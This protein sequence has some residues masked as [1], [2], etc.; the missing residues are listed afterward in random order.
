MNVCVYCSS[1]DRVDRAFFDVA[2]ELGV[3]LGKRRNNLVF[4]GGNT[5][6]MH[7]LAV[8][9]KENGG[10][11]LSVMALGAYAGYHGNRWLRDL[12]RERGAEHAGLVVASGR[13]SALDAWR[14]DG[15]ANRILGGDPESST[16]DV[17]VVPG[18]TAVAA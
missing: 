9:V 4:G 18:H 1:S 5:G 11:V 14:R 15:G 13:R 12:A 6:P 8:A 17:Y 7:A 16:A 2:S 3:L 10:R